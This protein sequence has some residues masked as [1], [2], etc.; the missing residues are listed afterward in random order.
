MPYKVCD[1]VD[2]QCGRCKLLLA[3]TVVAVQEGVPALIR[4]LTCGNEHKYRPPSGSSSGKKRSVR[5]KKADPAEKKA[6]HNLQLWLD[7][8]D[9][10]D[11]VSAKPYAI[12]GSFRV[13]D[14][15]KH[16]KFGVGVVISVLSP[17]SIIALFQEGEKSLIQNRS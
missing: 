8:V 16:Q 17:Q 13:N 14:L 10:M 2:A 1:E 6:K 11:P 15:I 3:H 9:G 7:R 5:V 12:S 4:C